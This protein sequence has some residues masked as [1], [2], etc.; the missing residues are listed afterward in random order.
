[1]E[2]LY[3]K[4]G[5]NEEV[6]SKGRYAELY[7]DARPFRPDEEKLFVE[8]AHYMYKQFR[9]D[10]ARSRSIRWSRKF[11]FCNRVAY[12][13][14]NGKCLLMLEWGDAFY[15]PFTFDVLI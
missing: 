8:Q 4:I 2:K 5:Y 6:V 12:V 10:A 1:M 14:A 15:L 7:T 13:N 3:E 11:G 9:D